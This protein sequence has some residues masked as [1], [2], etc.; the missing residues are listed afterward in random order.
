MSMIRISIYDDFPNIGESWANKIRGACDNANVTAV[1]RNS[2]QDLM[3][4]IN[5]RRTAWRPGSN[6]DIS[7]DPIDVDEAGIV[8][9]DYDLLR[10]S[11]SGDTTGSR[12][13][14]LLRC[15]T[16]CGLII[17]LNEYGTNTFD[18]SLRSPTQG[19]ADLHLGAA[20]IGNPGLWTGSFEGYRPWHWPV[21]PHARENF[22]RC[23]EDVREHL[24]EPV[25]EFLGLERFI[26][27]MPKRAHDFFLGGGDMETVRFS[28]FVNRARGGIEAKDKLSPEC[29]A[30]V[31]AA[32]LVA[33]LNGLILP[34]QSLLVDAPH[35][36]SR[37]PS[38]IRDEAQDIHH[39][40]RLCDP[41][42]EGIDDLL[43]GA[44]TAH[45]FNNRHWLWRP[46]WYWPD[47]ARDERIAE[48]RD[49]WTVK[50]VDWVFCE[51]VSRFLPAE[52]AV[53]FRA[54]LAPPFN[55][56]YVLKRNVPETFAFVG[57][58]GSEG[59][60]DPLIV[61]YVPQAAFSV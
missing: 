39:W 55:K 31:A 32:R 9:V 34:E 27:W 13:A 7:T 15:F 20:Q 48:V 8:V 19:F 36:V 2:F 23:V 59:S 46:A 3:E 5:R 43:E 16:K 51:N 53:D 58:V 52:F 44:L 12:L 17:V 40:N 56:R 47:I 11:E 1:D 38:L 42:D 25:L 61:E 14:Y 29:T 57:N 4:E 60:Q 49:P 21:L 50:D 35:L 30:R 10:Y 54:D 37:F 41:L 22:E 18:M 24:D 33:L 6:E 45:R 26:D 28:T